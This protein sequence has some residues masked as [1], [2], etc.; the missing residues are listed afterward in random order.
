MPPSHTP[1][2]DLESF[3]WVLLYDLLRWTG[4]RTK[5]EQVWWRQLNADTL[6]IAAPSKHVTLSTWAD[7]ELCKQIK[8]SS[9][10][11]PFREL[12][13]KLFA[14]AA[15]FEKEMRTTS[16]ADLIDLFNRAYIQFVRILEG[17]IPLLRTKFTSRKD[18]K[19]KEVSKGLKKGKKG[20]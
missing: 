4:K 1:I 7:P 8:L 2:D 12:L 3:V 6:D 14:S 13:H 10:L 15:S 18:S 11:R 9:I 20:I 5:P 19:D 17:H 16:E